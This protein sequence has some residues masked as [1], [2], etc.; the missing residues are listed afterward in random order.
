MLDLGQAVRLASPAQRRALEVRDRGCVFAGCNR[1]ASWCDAHHVL[2]F[3]R[4]GATALNNM[5]L[6]CPAHHALIHTGQWEVCMLDGVPHTRPA[7]GRKTAAIYGT[8]VS[9]DGW[10]RNTYF[11]RLDAA[12][13]TGKAIRDNRP[14]PG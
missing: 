8:A 4:G 5:V 7:P 1:P 13:Q 3:S 6:L 2:W 9:A 11:D 12:R 14:P 10:I